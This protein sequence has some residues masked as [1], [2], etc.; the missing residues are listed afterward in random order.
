MCGRAINDT[1]DFESTLN[2]VPSKK[3]ITS[4]PAK[5]LQRNQKEN[6]KSIIGQ[7]IPEIQNHKTE[8]IIPLELLHRDEVKEPKP[9][10]IFYYECPITSDKCQK[11]RSIEDVYAHVAAHHRMPKDVL[12]KTGLKIPEKILK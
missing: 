2:L 12:E 6:D 11:W 3:I 7:P 4:T 10:I 9:L 5:Y 8:H 1:N